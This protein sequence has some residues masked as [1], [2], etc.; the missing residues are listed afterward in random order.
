MAA[1]SKEIPLTVISRYAM[2]IKLPQTNQAPLPGEWATVSGF[3]AWCD[4]QINPFCSQNRN[5]GRTD[6]VRLVFRG[7]II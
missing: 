4:R 6:W 3:G 7:Y 2:P 1:R 5:F